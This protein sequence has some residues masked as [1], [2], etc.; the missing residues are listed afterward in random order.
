M[1]TTTG[2]MTFE[3]FERLSDEEYTLELLDGEVVRMPPA[4]TNHMRIARRL[5]LILANVVKQLHEKRLGLDLGEVFIETGYRVGPNW[6]IPDV[7][8]AHPGHPEDRYLQGSPALAVEVIS[9]ANTARMMHRKTKRLMEYG[10]REVWLVYP[11]T[12]S[13]AIYRGNRAVEIE[14]ILS[15]ELLPGVTI[16]LAEVFGSES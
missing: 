8:I 3:E 2:L 11:E 10:A 1:G 5:F 15:S 13:V 6:V 7:S 16:D 9:E 4:E 14:G 12:R